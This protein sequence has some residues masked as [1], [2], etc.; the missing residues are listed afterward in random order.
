MRHF[1]IAGIGIAAGF[2]T[3]IGLGAGT[4]HGFLAG[5]SSSASAQSAACV[6]PTAPSPTPEETAWRLF[7]AANCPGNGA[8]VVWENWIEQSELY[9]ASGAGVA[10][11]GPPPKRLHGSPLANALSARRRGVRALLTPATD[12]NPMGGPPPNVTS[13]ATICEE[14]HINA[15]A[16]SFVTTNGY[17]L[18]PGQAAAAQKGTDIEF[19]TPA[20]EVKVDWIPGTDFTP[21]FTC[22]NPPAGVRVETIDGTCYAMAGMHISS[23]LLTDWIWATFEPQSML[24]NPLRCITF[25]DCHDAWGASPAVSSGGAGGLTTLS[26]A[27]Q[28][29]MTQANLAPEFANYRL[30]GAQIK[31]TVGNNRPTYLGN[32][33]IEG[34]N[35]GMTKNT[36]SCITCHSA[37]FIAKNGTDGIDSLNA[38]V[39]PRVKI[40]AGSV[41]RDFAWSM[42]LACPKDPNGTPGRCH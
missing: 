4:D 13:G 24:T 33:V 27:L 3:V 5:F 34:E 42:F 38:P 16:A 10:A 41:A 6:F 9:P 35:V 37:S 40:P 36:A 23:K 26:P 21:A 11:A 8:Q 31:F 39:G 14:V 19:P 32:S 7:V 17:Q 1:G 12:C 15:E 25:G 29:L 20:I 2:A 30:D 22:A 28:S 18:R